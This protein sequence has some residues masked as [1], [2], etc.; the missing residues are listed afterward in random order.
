[1]AV[2]YGAILTEAAL[3]ESLDRLTAADEGWVIGHRFGPPIFER[4]RREGDRL[5]SLSPLAQWESGRLFAAA[6]ELRFRRSAPGFRVLLIHED[7]AP[8]GLFVAGAQQPLD[9]EAGEDRLYLWGER[10]HGGRY[11]YEDRIPRR[12]DYPGPPAPRLLVRVRRYVDA[13]GGEWTRF[14]GLEGAEA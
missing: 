2:A 13:E 12:F 8:P 1:M 3:Q 4:W 14:A 10:E 9:P 5:I 6:W 11:W 7:A